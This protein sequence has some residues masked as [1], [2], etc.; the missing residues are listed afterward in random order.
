LGHH[1]PPAEELAFGSTDTIILD[2]R[3]RVLPVTE[4]KAAYIPVTVGRKN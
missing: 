3:A 2:K 4:S 1:C